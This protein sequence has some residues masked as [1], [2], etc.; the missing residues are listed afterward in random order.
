MAGS[1]RTWLVFRLEKQRD[2]ETLTRVSE[3]LYYFILMWRAF[4]LKEGF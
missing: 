2:A 3:S 1:L 4:P